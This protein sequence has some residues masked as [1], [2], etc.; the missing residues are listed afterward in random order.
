MGLFNRLTGGRAS[1]GSFDRPRQG[2][3]GGALA[4]NYSAALQPT[5]PNAITPSNPGSFS[6]IRSAPILTQPRYFSAQEAA[7]IRQEAA[8][9]QRDLTSTK[10]AYKGLKKMVK[11]DAVTHVEHRQYETVLGRSEAKKKRADVNHAKAMIGL[12]PAYAGMG[13][14]LSLAADRASAQIQA[15]SQQRLQRHNQNKARLQGV[16]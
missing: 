2:G 12:T 11:A 1:G 13:E 15:N 6:T 9:K 3:S 14:S 5:E 7:A 8:K 10:S 4:Q 16:R